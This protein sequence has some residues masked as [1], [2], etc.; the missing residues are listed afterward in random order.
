[1]EHATQERSV[2]TGTAQREEKRA[3]GLDFHSGRLADCSGAQPHE[4]GYSGRAPA[5]LVGAAW[6]AGVLSL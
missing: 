4:A 3:R 6:L 2:P 5:S 1:M